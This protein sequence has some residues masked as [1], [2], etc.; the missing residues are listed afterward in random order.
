[1]VMYSLLK[2]LFGAGKDNVVVHRDSYQIKITH[3]F[4]VFC[5]ISPECT[6][7]A[8][9]TTKRESFFSRLLVPTL[10]VIDLDTLEHRKFQIGGEEKYRIPFKGAIGYLKFLD[11]DH[12]EVKVTYFDDHNKIVNIHTGA[13]EIGYT[14]DLPS[15]ITP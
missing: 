15:D 10:H 8:F 13:H 3:D 14:T 2:S 12:I 5:S 11:N 7:M 1:M 4:G 6:H 9:L